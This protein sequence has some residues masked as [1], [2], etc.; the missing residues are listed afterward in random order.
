MLQLLGAPLQP[1]PPALQLLAVGAALQLLAAVGAALQL[2]AAVGVPPVVGAQKEAVVK[3]A[4][5]ASAPAAAAVRAAVRAAL[6]AAAAP[7]LQS[8][9]RLAAFK[10]AEAPAPTPAAAAAAAA[11]LSPLPQSVGCRGR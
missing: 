5:A 3:L 7:P 10:A 6:N 9:P 11:A 2:L 4:K 8:K 1:P